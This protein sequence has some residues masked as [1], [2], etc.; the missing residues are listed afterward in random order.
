MKQVAPA[1]SDAEWDVMGVLWDAPAPL[2]AGDVI[3]RLA[4]RRAWTDRTI[5]TLLNRLVKKRAL[6]FEVDGNR[7]LY[8]PAVPREQCVRAAGRSF[9][10]RVF[11]GSAG[12]MLVHFVTQADL[13]SAEVAELQALLAKKSVKPK[14]PREGR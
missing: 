9:L 11:N 5:K 13:S 8:R 12:P 1:I 4:G 3:D 6:A 7:Y 2:R 10:S 14:L